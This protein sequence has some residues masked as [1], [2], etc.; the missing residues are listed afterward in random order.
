M[1]M[2]RFLRFLSSFCFVIWVR[3]I[4]I[5]RRRLRVR[6]K[7]NGGL[8]MGGIELDLV[9]LFEYRNVWGVNIFFR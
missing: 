9:L 1:W 8:N 5:R 2:R 7:C 6:S 3:R 4:R